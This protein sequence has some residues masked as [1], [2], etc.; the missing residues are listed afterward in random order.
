MRQIRT[1]TAEGLNWQLY[2]GEGYVEKDSSA[3]QEV[4][5]TSTGRGEGST[6][7]MNEGCTHCW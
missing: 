4:R 3:V 1:L 5:L 2:A 7:G 6:G